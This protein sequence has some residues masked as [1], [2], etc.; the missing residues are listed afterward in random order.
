MY[1]TIAE[2]ALTAAA[3]AAPARAQTWENPL[4]ISGATYSNFQNG[5]NY[6]TQTLLMDNGIFLIQAPAVI[7]R[8]NQFSLPPKYIAK[9]WHLTLQPFNPVDLSLWVCRTRSGSVVSNCVDASDNMDN[10]PEFV[11][12]PST[13]GSYYVVVTGGVMGQSP[14]CGNFSLSGY[15]G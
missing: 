4:L 8:V 11:T 9:P 7:Y 5:C 6:P 1:K 13:M 2:L 10:Q 14:T 15:R 3:F 12:V